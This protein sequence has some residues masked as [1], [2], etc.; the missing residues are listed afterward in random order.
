MPRLSFKPDASFFRK[1]VVGA[2]GAR[3][4]VLDLRERGHRFVELE[5]G[6][7]ETKLWKEVKRKRVRIPDLVCL[8]CGARLECRAKTDLELSMSHSPTDA[9]RAWDFGMVDTDWIA[10][11][12]CD[13]VNEAD[14]SAGAFDGSISYWRQKS[15]IR[16]QATGTINYFTVAEF[17]SAL[18]ARSR[19]KGVEEGSE[20]VIAWD[21]TFSTRTGVVEKIT[22]VEGGD[23][24]ITI[25]RDSDNH[26]YTWT[27]GKNKRVV[28][29]DGQQVGNHQVLGSTVSP[30]QPSALSCAGHPS[31]HHIATLL[32][33]RERTQRYTGV[34]LAR[35]RN[36]A[37]HRDEIQELAKDGEEDVY[38]RL[39]AVSYLNA[40]CGESARPLFTPYLSSADEQTQLEA[41]IA[42]GESASNET[43]EILCE[44]LADN[45]RPYFLRSAAA[46]A[47]R[48]TGSLKASNQLVLAFTDES[49]SL[50]HEALDALAAIGE[51]AVPVLLAGLRNQKVAIAA[52]CAE[53]LRRSA[54]SAQLLNTLVAELQSESPA[55]WAVWLA[56]NLPREHFATAIAQ[57]QHAR[58][59]LHYALSVLWSF[60]DSWIAPRWELLP[61][62]HFPTH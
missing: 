30:L 41:V 60:L 23:H 62:P 8:R 58:P 3:V 17:R 15:W 7:T 33:S 31:E 5:R 35:L 45:G 29:A 24:K 56:G 27:I 52:G 6:S 39:E 38:I 46:W 47:L 16:W 10:F 34:K 11:P 43:I 28:V 59:E 21:A 13:V 9:E 18:H 22:G 32:Q 53:A 51:P 57:L 54:T 49:V 1:I 61:A 50:R 48:R 4:V 14:W 42:L 2:V 55:T 44:I 12:V 19:T 20:N 25:R 36:E 26:R 37:D 40:I